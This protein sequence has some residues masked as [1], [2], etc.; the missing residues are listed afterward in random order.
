MDKEVS[1]Y[2]MY[3][4]GGYVER[5]ENKQVG[6]LYVWMYVP[7]DVYTVVR[8]CLDGCCEGVDY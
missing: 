8:R 3:G 1:T 2:S 7:M 6:R 4:T 5:R